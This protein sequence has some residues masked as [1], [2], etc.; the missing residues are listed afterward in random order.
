M[1]VS[2]RDIDT[3]ATLGLGWA[4]VKYAEGVHD[5]RIFAGDEPEIGAQQSPPAVVERDAFRAF[6][7]K[8]N[9]LRDQVRQGEE[10]KE[11]EAVTARRTIKTLEELD[12]LPANA[13]VL[14][15]QH[16]TVA[17]KEGTDEWY[18]DGIYLNAR[19]IDLPCTVIYEPGVK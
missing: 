18:Q 4:H 14:E 19:Q 9:A 12:A 15:D 17:L 8:I 11:A 2:V 3:I 16:D 5:G 6:A 7:N 10:S 1:V 13:V